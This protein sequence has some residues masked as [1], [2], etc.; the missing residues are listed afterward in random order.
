MSPRRGKRR[1]S[2]FN[3]L[4]GRGGAWRLRLPRQ[5]Q[6]NTPN[7]GMFSFV[8]RRWTGVPGRGHR[9]SPPEQP[10]LGDT[11]QQS[12]QVALPRGGAAGGLEPGQNPAVDEQYDGGNQKIR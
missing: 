3:L 4:M 11:D 6:L 5:L 10:H 1:R 12:E 8:A 7:S 2:R 9:R